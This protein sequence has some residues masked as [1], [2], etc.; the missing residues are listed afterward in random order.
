LRLRS[1]NPEVSCDE[2]LEPI[3]GAIRRAIW[4]RRLRLLHRQGRLADVGLWAGRLGLHPL[5][6]ASIADVGY[7]GEA[8]AAIER[9]SIIL[10]NGRLTPGELPEQIIRARRALDL[11][12]ERFQTHPAPAGRADSPSLVPA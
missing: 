1:A 6:A 2:A 9:F 7:F 11:V 8:W 3:S 4:R 10:R 12:R 5:R